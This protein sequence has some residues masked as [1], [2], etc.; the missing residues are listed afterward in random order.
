MNIKKYETC[1]S[2]D[3]YLKSNEIRIKSIPK[4]IEN[5][6]IIFY[7]NITYQTFLGFGGALTESTGFAFSKL[8]TENQDSILND[9]ISNK[10]LNYNFI[11]L[12]IGSSDFSL[13]PYSYAYKKDLSDFNISED[14]KYILPLLRKICEKKKNIGLISSPWSPPAFMKNTHILTLGGSL[15]EKYYELYAEYIVKY[16][17]EYERNGFKIEYLT[18]Q[19]EPNAIQKWESCLYSPEE[20]IRF[21]TNYLYRK[22][23]GQNLD[24]KLLIWDH[25]K[26]NLLERAEKEFRYDDAINKIAGIAFHYYSGDHFENIR[27]FSEK[28]PDKLLVASEICTGI[29]ENI[30]DVKNGE[31]YAH[32]IIGDLNSGTNIYVDWNMILEKNGGPNHKGNFCSSPLM[33]NSDSSNYI[34]NP[35]YY[36][37]QHFS[38]FIKPKA[39]RIAYS[40]FTENLEITGFKNENESIVIVVLNKSQYNEKVNFCITDI[41]IDDEIKEHSIVTYVI[42]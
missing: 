20:E 23:K 6:K 10:G 42:E 38:R 5:R 31:I 15:K 26:D 18:I 36:Y 9:I 22:I 27:L 8:S 29:N 30:K 4:R 19:N 33:L 7:P 34:K 17:K 1:I 25:N 3:E 11:R 40:K 39:K 12:P 32:D 21:A 13:K 14:E 24:T 28:Y 37:I 2:D 35:Q 41:L 16:I